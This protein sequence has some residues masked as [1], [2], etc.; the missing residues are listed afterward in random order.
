MYRLSSPAW[1]NWSKSPEGVRGVPSL[2]AVFPPGKTALFT[3]VG[4][5]ASGD[6]L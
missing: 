1:I 5:T 2:I 3:I 6:L 4:S